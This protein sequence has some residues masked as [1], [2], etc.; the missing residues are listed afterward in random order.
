MNNYPSSIVWIQVVYIGVA[1]ID[2]VSVPFAE[3]LSMSSTQV[4]SK[5]TK[6]KHPIMTLIVQIAAKK[7]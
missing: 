4:D 2:H 3:L 5:E 6:K 1:V 7:I